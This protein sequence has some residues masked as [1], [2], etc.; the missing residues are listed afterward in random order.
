MY[1]NFLLTCMFDDEGPVMGLDLSCVSYYSCPNL[2]ILESNASTWNLNPSPDETCREN[3][4][5]KRATSIPVYL[6]NVGTYPCYTNFS[7]GSNNSVNSLPRVH[8]IRDHIRTYS[9]IYRA[10]EAV[11]EA[12]QD[13]INSEG[14]AAE[15]EDGGADG[16][17]LAHL[18]IACA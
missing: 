6:G 2:P 4:R 11:E 1:I 14:G 16:M 8:N 3:K 10:A 18:L 17:R 7:R 15:E 12:A 13:M 9:Q 5:L